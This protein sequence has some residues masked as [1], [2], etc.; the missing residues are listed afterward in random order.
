MRPFRTNSHCR[1]NALATIHFLGRVPFLVLIPD[2][3]P[4]RSGTLYCLAGRAEFHGFSTKQ[5]QEQ[6]AQTLQYPMRQ[7]RP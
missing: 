6:L 3:L 4:S 5:E 7:G 2:R 1:R